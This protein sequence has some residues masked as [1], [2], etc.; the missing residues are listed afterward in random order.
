M[1]V[2]LCLSAAECLCQNGG[3]CVG[4][5]GT[6]KCPSGFT[7]AYCQLGGYDLF[8]PFNEWVTLCLRDLFQRFIYLLF[9]I[10]PNSGITQ[11]LCSTS[12]T[13]PDGSPCLEYGGA[14]LCTC[15]TGVELDHMDFYPGKT[16]AAAV[17]VRSFH[18]LQGYECRINVGLAT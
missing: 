1:S 17:L 3:V 13:C 6:C 11:T 4:I 18:T 5:N 2:C 9:T 12:R 10:P 15:H 7:G 16:L 8:N 14:Y